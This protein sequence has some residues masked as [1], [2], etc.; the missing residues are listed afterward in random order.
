VRRRK[1]VCS[2][3]LQRAGVLVDK[4]LRFFIN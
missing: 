1:T 3:R 4:I 2:T